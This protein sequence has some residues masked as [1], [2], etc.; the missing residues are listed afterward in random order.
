[1][2]RP[3]IVVASVVLGLAALASIP[4]RVHGGNADGVEN[5]GASAKAVHAGSPTADHAVG[6]ADCPQCDMPLLDGARFCNQC[7]MSELATSKTG[8]TVA[9]APASIAIQSNEGEGR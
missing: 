6:R 3:P 5:V 7:G 9:A 4:S 8:R 2:P 1:M